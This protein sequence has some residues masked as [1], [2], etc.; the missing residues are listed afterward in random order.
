MLKFNAN[1]LCRR[2]V[3]RVF[4]KVAEGRGECPTYYNRR[5]SRR[6]HPGLHS[7]S[8][9]SVPRDIG[10]PQLAMHSC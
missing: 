9:V 4:R 6:Q 2:P 8:H 5:T 10:L 7:I 1:A 3:R